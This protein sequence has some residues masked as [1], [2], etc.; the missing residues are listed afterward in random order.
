MSD[1]LNII[2]ISAASDWFFGSHSDTIENCE[3][4]AC[5]A[6]VEFSR[7]GSLERTIIPI[8]EFTVS[9]ESSFLMGHDLSSFRKPIVH[10]K[11]LYSDSD[12]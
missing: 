11:N 10:R 2:S 5:F 1:I 12:D 3:P 9:N 8:D 7:N 4:V 6:L